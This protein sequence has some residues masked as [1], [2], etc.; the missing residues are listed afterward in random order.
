MECFLDY[1]SYISVGWSIGESNGLLFYV[2]SRVYHPLEILC[3]SWLLTV[4]SG[5]RR[6]AAA[7]EAG[8]GEV[9]RI[10][11]PLYLSLLELSFM[12]AT[13]FLLAPSGQL[14]LFSLPRTLCDTTEALL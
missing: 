11:P 8:A 7:M 4:L 9:G 14:R 2:R 3:G 6:K 10:H 1:T 13:F 12:K 5:S